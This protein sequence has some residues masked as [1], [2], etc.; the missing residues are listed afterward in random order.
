MIYN[1]NYVLTVLGS[2]MA[3]GGFS[4]YSV[5][6]SFIIEPYGFDSSDASYMMG[7]IY[8]IKY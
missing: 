1:K 4:G 8:N 3:F 5:T 7:N 2:C 6:M